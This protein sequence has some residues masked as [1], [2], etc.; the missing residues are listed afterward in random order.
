MQRN[1]KA[2]LITRYS[3]ALRSLALNLILG[4]RLICDR[5]LLAASVIVQDPQLGYMLFK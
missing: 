1:L 4:Q 2:C 5:L 3:A